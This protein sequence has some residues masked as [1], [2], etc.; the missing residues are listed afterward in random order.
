MIDFD[1]PNLDS[2]KKQLKKICQQLDQ[3][4]F[5]S[6]EEQLLFATTADRKVV[7]RLVTTSRIRAWEANLSQ[8]TNCG[9]VYI[10]I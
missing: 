3:W 8:N 2:Y 10:T 9:K 1:N 5:L 7:E 6:I 4:R